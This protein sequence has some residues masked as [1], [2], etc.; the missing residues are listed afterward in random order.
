MIQAYV[1][2]IS[3]IGPI[4]DSFSIGST[5]GPGADKK[6]SFNKFKQSP[7]TELNDTSVFCDIFCVGPGGMWCKYS[8]SS[9]KLPFTTPK[10]KVPCKAKGGCSPTTTTEGI[11]ASVAYTPPGDTEAWC[12]KCFGCDRN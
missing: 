11:D 4:K 12:E 7:I 3:S 10:P 1:A 6:S 5:D 9:K 2:Y 8:Q